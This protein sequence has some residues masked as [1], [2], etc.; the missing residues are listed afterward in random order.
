LHYSSDLDLLILYD[1]PPPESSP[2]TRT[3]WQLCADGRVERLLELLGGVTPEGVA[4]KI[5]LRLR[6]E[7]TGGLLARSWSSFLDHARRYMQ[8]WERMALVRS[9]VVSGSEETSSRWSEAMKEIVYNF[10]W[11]KDAIGAIRHLK[12]RI[13]SESN[14]EDRVYVD[15]KFG[16]GGIADLEFLVQLLQV[17]HGH[18]ASALCTPQI[19][20]AISCLRDT[21]VISPQEC[22]GLQNAHRFQRML[23]NHYQ[24]IEEWTSREVSRESPV[25][26]RLARNLSYQGS[27]P[28]DARKALLNEWDGHARTVRSLVEKLFYGNG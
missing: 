10:S 12:R 3:D 26:E 23:E 7:G 25:L 13:E 18:K 21:G 17:Q 28:G 15:F 20:D 14:K 11:D 9:R 2:E 22:E 27:T 19:A 4:Y 8:P 6:P 16:S 5:D 1:D 24:L